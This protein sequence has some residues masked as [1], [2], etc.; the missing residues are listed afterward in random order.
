MDR[1]LRQPLQG[2]I[3]IIRFNWPLYTIA[4]GLVLVLAI[5]GY[6]IPSFKY[7]CLI[8]GSA[9]FLPILLSLLTSWF[10]YDY[11][12][13]YQLPWIHQ[14]KGQPTD[15][16]VNINA[17]FD[18][19]SDTIKA[20][21]SYQHFYIFDFYN[22]DTH[23]EA[24]IKRARKRYPA[25]EETRSIQTHSI[26]LNDN[27]VDKIFV[28]FS[29]HEIRD[30]AERILFFSELHR[31][32]KQGGRIYLTEHLRDIANLL[33]YN[34]GFLHFYTG[35]MWQ[36]NIEQSGLRIVQQQKTTPFVTTFTILKNGISS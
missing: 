4:L 36:C 26:P 28:I 3:N 30:E 11:S 9:I 1:P 34:I 8:A 16:I 12:S 21:L 23:T 32:L 14:L 6:L 10:V 24:S 31:I 25:P 17:G 13:L 29:A 27:S 33:A 7:I 5:S 15:V 18:E 22:P 19:T 20:T 2:T 35:N